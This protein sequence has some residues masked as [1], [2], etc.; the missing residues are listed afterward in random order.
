MNNTKQALKGM[1]IG[2]LIVSALNFFGCLSSNSHN[3]LKFYA[4][5]VLDV[6]SGFYKN[7]EG[8][9]IGIRSASYGENDYMV[10]FNCS[11]S[12]PSVFSV[13][14]KLEPVWINSSD[15]SDMLKK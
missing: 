8:I 5:D 7:C 13:V 3:K 6:K 12:N 11:V 10:S 15:I 4:G 9:V 14:T 1:L 2:F